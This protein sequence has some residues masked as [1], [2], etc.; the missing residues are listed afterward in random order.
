[1]PQM[2]AADT[3]LVLYALGL[4]RTLSNRKSL[5]GRLGLFEQPVDL[6]YTDLLAAVVSPV[7]DTNRLK[8]AS[9]ETL[10][11]YKDVVE[12]AFV[13]GTVLPMQFGTCVPSAAALMNALQ[14]QGKRY[15]EQ[16]HALEGCAE[17]GLR[18]RLVPADTA[19]D[20]AEAPDGRAPAERPGTSYLLRRQRERS[21]LSAS[22]HRIVG[23][24]RS[25]LD[26]FTVAT[27]IPK[28][29]AGKAHSVVS[30]AFLIQRA[31]AQSFRQEALRLSVPGLNGL[32]VV[33]PWPPYSFV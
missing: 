19:P 17:M 25:A 8:E 3:P 2:P 6:V 22:T 33:G 9:V 23:D 29:V 28:R 10:L 27:S 16:L 12:S 21:G 13:S 15:R 30:I 11:L 4:K 5:A 14:D 32:D 18:M 7:S 20:D 26:A 24:V 31:H 1:M